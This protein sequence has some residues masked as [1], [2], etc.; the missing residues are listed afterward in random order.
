MPSDNPSSHLEIPLIQSFCRELL[1]GIQ[2]LHDQNII[3]RDL[4]PANILISQDGVLKLADFGC[5]YNVATDATVVTQTLC[6][7]PGYM[8]PEIAQNEKHT[9]ASDI[10][11][12]GAVVFEM[13]IGRRAQPVRSNH[14]HLWDLQR[15]IVNIRWDGCDE[16]LP[17]DLVDM[18]NQSMVPIL[19]RGPP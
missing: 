12:F 16:A 1:H 13:A 2:Y 17:D 5:A 3:H 14:A 11:S 9:T 8:A 10:F 7:T 18:V 19:S 4:K 6:G 15:N